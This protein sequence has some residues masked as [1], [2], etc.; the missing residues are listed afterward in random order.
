MQERVGLT[1]GATSLCWQE[2]MESRA[3]E[4]WPVM[5]THTGDPQCWVLVQA[6]GQLW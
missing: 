1:A 2:R 6:W 3:H 5:G 4:T